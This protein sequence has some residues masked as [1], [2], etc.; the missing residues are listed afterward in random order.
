MAAPQK[1]RGEIPNTPANRGAI[2][3]RIENKLGPVGAGHHESHRREHLM[4][5]L[6]QKGKA[7]KK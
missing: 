2:V 6:A 3:D 1:K 5:W 4:Q 7:T